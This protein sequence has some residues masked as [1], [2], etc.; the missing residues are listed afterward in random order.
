MHIDAARKLILKRNLHFI[1]IDSYDPEMKKFWIRLARTN[2]FWFAQDTF[3]VPCTY[4]GQFTGN[5][6]D[7]LD[8][9]EADSH[10]EAGLRFSI[11]LTSLDEKRVWLQVGSYYCDSLR[12]CRV[13]LEFSARTELTEINEKIEKALDSVL[14]KEAREIYFKRMQ[15]KEDQEILS[16]LCGLYKSAE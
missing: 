6:K 12:G 2:G 14:K 9:F 3:R 5:K 7:F 1:V 11:L 16:I 13:S 8:H 15:E 4:P 10:F